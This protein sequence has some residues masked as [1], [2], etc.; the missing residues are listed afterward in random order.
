MYSD[1]LHEMQSRIEEK[2][3]TYVELK[4][5]RHAE[6]QD[7]ARE[8]DLMMDRRRNRKARIKQNV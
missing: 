7:L 6:L 2:E 3:K 5:Q 8:V 1:I 4:R